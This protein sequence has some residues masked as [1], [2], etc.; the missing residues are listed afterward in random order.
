MRQYQNGTS[1]V[2]NP[3]VGTYPTPSTP[4]LPTPHPQTPTHTK[5][6]TS[7][8]P[9]P[10]TTPSTK[11]STKPTTPTDPA[12]PKPEPEK[13]T[14][15]P[16]H[17]AKLELIGSPELKAEAGAAF[18]AVPRIKAVL[19][20]GKPAAR[21][22]ILFAIEDDTT[23]GTNFGQEGKAHLAV[24]TDAEGIAAAPG[25]KAGAAAG[26]FT[27]RATGYDTTTQFTVKFNGT[28]AAK[29]APAAAD[30][31]TRTDAGA[32]KPLEVVAGDAVKGVEVQATARGKAVEGTQVTAGLVEQ[33]AAGEWVPVDP[34]KAKGPYF[35]G[36]KDG[37][38]LFSLNLAPSGADGK[39]AL[40]ELQTT[41]V[42][43]GTYHLRLITKEKVVLVL[44]L[45]VTA[46]AE[47]SRPP[48]Q[49]TQPPAQPAT[50]Q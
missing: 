17:L 44:E 34:A 42:A 27:L 33:N 49:Q 22:F 14:P 7:T 40:P 38:K 16:A 31:L 25:L 15:A 6:N 30:L 37:E 3:P 24:Q 11:P 2:P 12:K 10:S 26:T 50:K 47:G 48:A 23:G 13:P 19:S 9:N 32:A 39:I 36:A 5:P 21:Q 8:T 28:V 35:K 4:V 1:E 45:K 41:D 20:D 43:P 18:T 29:P 46:K